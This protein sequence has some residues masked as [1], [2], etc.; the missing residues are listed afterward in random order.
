MVLMN[1]KVRLSWNF[2]TDANP[3]VFAT[4]ESGNL[5]AR[6]LQD[7]QLSLFW[8]STAYTNGNI[9]PQEFE[10]DYGRL[11]PVS[12][13]CLYRHNLSYGATI[14]K[15]I[16]RDDDF[17]EIV[18]DQTWRA[19]KVV[20]GLGEGAL[21]LIGLGGYSNENS[22]YPFTVEWHPRV[23]GKRERLIIT[24]ATNPN[25]YIQGGRYCA[26][27]YWEPEMANLTW[28]YQVKRVDNSKQFDLLNG[29]IRTE[30]RPSYRQVNV[31]FQHLTKLDENRLSELLTVRGKS[32]DLFVSIYP[33]E[34]SVNE[35]LHT[36]LGFLTDWDG[37]SRQ[38]VHFRD[39]SCTIRESI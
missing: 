5:Y 35:R 18:L 14:R 20:Y 33:E 9:P 23:I 16:C 11:R 4:S 25:G 13:F 17:N 10:F 1:N 19:V 31:S 34:G 6:N 39:F 37:I 26:G 15:I 38:N 22:I 32:A 30:K 29:G 24:D 21:G 12:F 36:M 7:Q 27:D 28:G 8:R 2:W 3:L